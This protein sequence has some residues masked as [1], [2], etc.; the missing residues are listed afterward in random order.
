MSQEVDW[1]DKAEPLEKLKG[2]A[3]LL[4]INERDSQALCHYFVSNGIL[5][6][7]EFYELLK[8]QIKDESLALQN[9]R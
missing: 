3:F 9:D 1:P 4:A 7:S 2:L 5:T 6:K 8:K